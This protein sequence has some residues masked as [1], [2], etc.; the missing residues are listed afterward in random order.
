M[1]IA[2]FVGELMWGISRNRRMNDSI[3]K[4]ARETNMRH[5]TASPADDQRNST[6][7]KTLSTGH[8]SP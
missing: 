1:S 3:A 8:K 6:P 4:I 5:R 7:A 2:R